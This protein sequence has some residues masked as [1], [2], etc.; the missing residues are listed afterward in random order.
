MPDPFL[1]DVFL[2]HNN[3]DKLAVHELAE[4]LKADHA[5]QPAFGIIEGINRE[6]E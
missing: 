6:K 5:V 1:Y 3:K 2:S 4:R